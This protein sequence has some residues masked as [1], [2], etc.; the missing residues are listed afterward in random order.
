MPKTITKTFADGM[1]LHVCDDITLAS[2]VE[3]RL[4]VGDYPM[5]VA[6]VVKAKRNNTP[7]S[8]KQHAHIFAFRTES[9]PMVSVAYSI[10]GT[11]F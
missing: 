6:Q 9:G 2:V 8:M 11:I 3:D 5:T 4:T 1:T 7:A 10:G